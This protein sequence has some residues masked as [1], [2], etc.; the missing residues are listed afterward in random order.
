[1]ITSAPPLYIK[2]TPSYNS[3]VLQLLLSR[4][5]STVHTPLLLS[6]FPT[7]PAKQPLPREIRT[8]HQVYSIYCS[9]ICTLFLHIEEATIF[10][11]HAAIR[12]YWRY[13][14]NAVIPTSSG[15]RWSP[16]PTVYIY[17]YL[18][19]STSS[20]RHGTGIFLR[21]PG[22]ARAL[23]FFVLFSVF[24]LFVFHGRF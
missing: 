3:T 4:R 22:V 21:S 5:N 9:D 11:L 2:K 20:G 10:E 15:H 16:A 1:M 6:L 14:S 12:H 17:F 7:R 23:L 18:A 13:I 8:V 24:I 19:I